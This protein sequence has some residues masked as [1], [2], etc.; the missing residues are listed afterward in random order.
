MDR[1]FFISAACGASLSL[2]IYAAPTGKA[3]KRI[4]FF[5]N[6]QGFDP[7]MFI[8]KDSKTL[9]S[10]FLNLFKKH[11]KKMTLLRNAT[12]SGGGGQHQQ[13]GS[14][15]TGTLN[16]VMPKFSTSIDQFL[17]D[18]V[19]K[20]SLFPSIVSR[21]TKPLNHTYITSWTGKGKPAS[22][23][24]DVAE[25]YNG[26]FKKLTKEDFLKEK[27]IIDKMAKPLLQK[28]KLLAGPEKQVLDAYIDS[29]HSMHKKLLSRMKI[30]P[31]HKYT[32]Q[33][34]TDLTTPAFDLQ[35]LRYQLEMSVF[36]LMNN[37]TNICATS[38]CGTRG[39]QLV[40]HDG[41]RTSSDYHAL[42][43]H[44]KRPDKWE[45]I[46]KIE[47]EQLQSVSQ[48]VDLLDS[49][50]EGSGTMLDNT[51]VVVYAGHTDSATHNTNK[52]PILLI[53]G[54]LKHKG[55]FDTKGQNSSDLLVTL[56]HAMGKP[57]KSY[58]NSERDINGVLL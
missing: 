28:R 24:F 35:R 13:P 37:F 49:V 18:T 20:D 30:N 32:K 25:M 53:G 12:Y 29:I 43:H 33:V 9:D 42:S 55:N 14:L 4:L 2:P 44:G 39:T 10:P 1:R 6:H 52:R 31:V 46:R 47:L 45:E 16:R 19:Q 27:T 26:L 54:N 34:P 38:L 8:P 5:C 56:C 51:L 41:T 50:P 21:A 17:A 22:S 48:A 7:P 58:A 57:V 36:A 23:Y 15:L 3:N 40:F 11:H